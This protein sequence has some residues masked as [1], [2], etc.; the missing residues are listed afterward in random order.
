MLRASYHHM[1]GVMT[2]YLKT[3]LAYEITLLESLN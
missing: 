1:I 3:L 2:A